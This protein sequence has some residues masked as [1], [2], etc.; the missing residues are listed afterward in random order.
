MPH[1]HSANL[2]HYDALDTPLKRRYSG[3]SAYSMVHL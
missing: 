1:Q 2:V 3:L